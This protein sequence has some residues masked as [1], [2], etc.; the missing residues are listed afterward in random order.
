MKTP[1]AAVYAN[2]HYLKLFR[3]F[4]PLRLAPQREAAVPAS[5][6]TIIGDVIIHPTAKVTLGGGLKTALMREGMEWQS[7]AAGHVLILTPTHCALIV[8]G[9]DG[10]VGTERDRERGRRHRRRSSNSGIYYPRRRDDSGA[11]LR[12]LLHRRM[13]Y[14]PRSLRQDRRYPWS[15]GLRLFLISFSF[16]CIDVKE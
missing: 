1:S 14:H 15:A 13:E 12:P 6:P 5:G 16:A 7:R 3:K 11:L 8:G 10:G 4:C 2:R 9:S